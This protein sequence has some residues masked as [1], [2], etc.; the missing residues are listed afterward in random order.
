MQQENS[1]SFI[2]SVI[3]LLFVVTFNNGISE[4]LNNKKVDNSG[5]YEK[6]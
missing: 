6:N 1:S 5:I 2:Q 3:K 4:Q